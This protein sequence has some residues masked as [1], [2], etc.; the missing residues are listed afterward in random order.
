MQKYFSLQAALKNNDALLL[1]HSSWYG[2]QHKTED[3]FRYFIDSMLYQSKISMFF[4]SDLL[5]RLFDV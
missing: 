1:E 2:M 4:G 5:L 3:S